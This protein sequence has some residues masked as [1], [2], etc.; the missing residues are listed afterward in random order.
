[1]KK[2]ITLT[3]VLSMVLVAGFLQPVFAQQNTGSAAVMLN[4]YSPRNWAAGAIPRSAES[5]Y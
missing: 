5:N 3:M 4:N 2:I 1:M